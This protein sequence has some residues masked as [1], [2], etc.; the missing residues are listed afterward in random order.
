[1]DQSL[2]R[3]VIVSLARDEAQ[4]EVELVGGG[5]RFRSGIEIDGVSRGFGC[6]IDHSLT[7]CATQRQT[8]SGGTHIKALKF[9]SVRRYLCRHC[10]P[11]NAPGGDAVHPSDEAP[12]VLIE[13]AC[14]EVG[15]LFFER[16]EA[17]VTSARLHEYPAAVFEQQLLRSGDR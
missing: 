8:A 17:K 6:A 10:T 14:R 4:F 1:M 13:I 2:Y 15:N 5:H 11:G 7:K 9:P 16:A 12:A 3:I